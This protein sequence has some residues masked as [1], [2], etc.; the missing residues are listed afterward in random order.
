MQKLKM[1]LKELEM[2][3]LQVIFN[4]VLLVHN[5]IKR[6]QKRWHA[7]LERMPS[8][9]RYALLSA[10]S[11]LASPEMVGAARAEGLQRQN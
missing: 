3:L 10:I 1:L 6:K 9:E 2:K 11:Q 7:R 4:V 5:R 8:V